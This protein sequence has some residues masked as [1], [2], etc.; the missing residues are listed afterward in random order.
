MESKYLENNKNS[1]NISQ[2][3]EMNIFYFFKTVLLVDE[4]EWV[5]WQRRF[6]FS[7]SKIGFNE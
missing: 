1:E 4:L 3:R 6:S 5:A 2:N 7:N